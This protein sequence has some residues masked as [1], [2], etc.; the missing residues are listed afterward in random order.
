VDHLVLLNGNAFAL[1]RIALDSHAEDAIFLCPFFGST[2]GLFHQS[3]HCVDIRPESTAYIDRDREDISVY[4]RGCLWGGQRDR[5]I[6][7]AQG[8][9][10][11]SLGARLGKDE[12]LV[13]R[14]FVTHRAEAQILDA[15]YIWHGSWGYNPHFDIRIVM[16]DKENTY[17]TLYQP[18]PDHRMRRY[19]EKL[20][21]DGP[22]YLGPGNWP[23]D[24]LEVARTSAEQGSASEKAAPAWWRSVNRVR[25]AWRLLAPPLVAD[26][27][28]YIRRRAMQARR[29]E[30]SG[31]PRA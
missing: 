31:P 10:E 7:A 13:N 16:V 30:L 25:R 11:I 2:T 17:S 22:F 18:I 9:H 24:I 28:H 26:L 20:N 19:A 27:P 5:A 3:Y 4:W 29:A 1:T 8:I 21:A 6:A 23:T 15:R 14:Y 12:K